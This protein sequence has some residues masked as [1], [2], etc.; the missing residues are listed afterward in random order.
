VVHKMRTCMRTLK[1]MFSC[2]RR[3][4][5][6]YQEE[7]DFE[8][9]PAGWHCLVGKRFALYDSCTLWRRSSSKCYLR[10]QSVPQR[11]HHTSPL[12]SSLFNA[13]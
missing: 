6:N 8:V 3:A 4:N 9:M 1:F 11:E 5:T 13:V 10:I 12:Q 7:E 2:K